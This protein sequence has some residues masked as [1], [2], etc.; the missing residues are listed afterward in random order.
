MRLWMKKVADVYA[1]QNESKPRLAGQVGDLL[2]GKGS[3][4]CYANK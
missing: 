1:G 4:K 3:L 2:T